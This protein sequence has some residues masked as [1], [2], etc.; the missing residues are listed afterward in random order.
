MGNIHFDQSMRII[1]EEMRIIDLFGKQ[2]HYQTVIL[3]YCMEINLH[4]PVS[5]IR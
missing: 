5:D 1:F 2:S 4:L 3:N